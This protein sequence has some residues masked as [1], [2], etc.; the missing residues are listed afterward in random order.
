MIYYGECGHF[1]HFERN[2]QFGG[3]FMWRLLP[4]NGGHRFC[5]IQM[6]WLNKE[7]PTSVRLH[8]FGRQTRSRVASIIASAI[9]PE[10]IIDAPKKELI[11][12]PVD[13]ELVE[14][15][16]FHPNAIHSRKL[17]LSILS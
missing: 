6:F 17:S 15:L 11:K 9:I 13:L 4:E 8:L 16:E 2:E 5:Q 12:I 1:R 10:I 3:I 14:I 7:T